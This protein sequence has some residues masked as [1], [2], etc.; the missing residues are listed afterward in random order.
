MRN[1][2]CNTNLHA[3]DDESEIGASNFSTYDNTK[4]HFAS[5]SGS[6]PPL[7]LVVAMKEKRE[8]HEPD[9]RESRFF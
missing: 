1:A 8:L 5:A 3:K 4:I 9:A 2:K 6:L 7:V